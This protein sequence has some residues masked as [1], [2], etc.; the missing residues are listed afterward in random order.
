VGRLGD[1]VARRPLDFYQAVGERLAVAGAGH[2]GA[3][4]HHR[5][6]QE[7]P[8]RLRMPRALEAL[9]AT[10]RRFRM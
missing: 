5:Q 6:H 10:L 4:I 2:N 7:E 3:P 9:D 1:H 8:G